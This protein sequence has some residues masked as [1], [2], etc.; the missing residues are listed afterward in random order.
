MT[1]RVGAGGLSE[2]RSR[3]T[4]IHP[5]CAWSLT[6]HRLRDQLIGRLRD[7]QTQAKGDDDHRQRRHRFCASRDEDDEAF[8]V[9]G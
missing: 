5:D 4:T 9:D 2:S 6:V 7:R 1:L 3:D 8:Y